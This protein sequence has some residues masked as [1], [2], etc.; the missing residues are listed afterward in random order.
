MNNEFTKED[1]LN[2]YKILGFNV[3]RLREKHNIS[4]LD[5]SYKMGYKSVSLVSAAELCLDSKHFNIEHIYKIA[6][7][8]N[9]DIC[10]LF[11]DIE[12]TASILDNFNPLNGTSA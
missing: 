3:K 8:L 6:C 12:T 10:E 5:L 2:I 4:Q 9:V 7:I 11:K 1:I